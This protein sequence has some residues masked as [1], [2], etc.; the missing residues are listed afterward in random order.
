MCDYF[1]EIWAD[2]F[3]KKGTEEIKKKALRNHNLMLNPIIFG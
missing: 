2:V 1:S 3:G